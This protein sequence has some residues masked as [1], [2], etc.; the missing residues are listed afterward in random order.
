MLLVASLALVFS[1]GQAQSVNPKLMSG[2]RWRNV[3]PFRGGRVSAVSGAIGKPGTF[4]MGMP[5]G[6]VWKTTNAGA[7]WEPIM[8]SVTDVASI[9]SI[10]VAPSNPNVIYVGTGDMPTGGSINEGNGMYKSVDAGKTW[11]HLAGFADSKQIPSLVVHPKNENIVLA[12]ISGDLSNKHENRGIYRSTDGG[13]TWTKTLFVDN[14]TGGQKIAYAY[15]TPDTLIATTMGHVAAPGTR[16]G[17]GSSKGGHLFKSTDNGVTWNEIK[18][19]GL[20]GVSGRT[21]VAIANGTNGERMFLVQG[22]GLY[23]SDDG[24]K[25]WKKL[26]SNDPR[27]RTGQGGYNCGVYVN[28]KNPDIVYIVN[29]CSYISYDG[30]NTFTGFKGAPGGDDPQQMWIDPTDGDR[31]FFGTDQGATISLD[32]G[33][34]WSSWYNQPTAQVYHIS[35]DNQY[36]YWIYATQQD[37]GSIGTSSRGNYGEITPL[38]WSPHPGYEFGSICAD[39]LNPKVTYAGSESSGVVKVTYP[40]MQFEE[41]SPNL[42]GRAG[43]RKVLNQPLQF[44]TYNPHELL[45]GFNSVWATTDGGTTWHALSHDLTIPNG[46]AP[47]A[48]EKP[49][50]VA[51]G[52]GGNA[53]DDDD[54]DEDED[55]P[56]L[57]D[58]DS[59][60]KQVGGRAAAIECLSTSTLDNGI[61]WAGTSNGLIQLTQ[62]HGGK[63]HEVSIPGLPNARRA[64]ISSISASSHNPAVAYVAVDLHGMADYKPYVFRTRD[65]GNTWQPI[66]TGLP[67]DEANGSFARVIKEDPVRPGLLYLGTESSVYVSF[68]DG[69]HW[70]SL[71]QNLPTTSYRD[72]VVKGNDLVV[73]TYGRSFWILDDLSPLREISANMESSAHF[74]KPATAV[75]VRRNV[76]WDTPFP[77]EVPH[78]LNAPVGALLYYYLPSDAKRVSLTVFDKRGSEVRRYSSDPIEQYTDKQPIPDFWIAP[79]KPMPTGSGLQRINWDLRYNELPS[80]NHS[81]DIN[82]NPGETVAS[83]QGPLV[84]PGEY[85]LVLIVDGQEF[86]QKLEVAN[87]PRSPSSARDL[88]RQCELQRYFYATA[89]SCWDNWQSVDAVRKEIADRLVANPAEPI[90]KALKDMDERLTAIQGAR[91]GGRRFAAAADQPTGAT[92]S[93]VMGVCGNMLRNMDNGD[94]KPSEA[95]EMAYKDVPGDAQWLAKEWESVKRKEIPALN[96]QLGKAGIKPLHVPF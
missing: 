41:V 22:S 65:F 34:T 73:G 36:P 8:D 92:F 27:I 35:V 51:P 5:N 50:E 16:G 44:S 47:K 70:Q 19:G 72:M 1:S 96:D 71:R 54:Q 23:R 84:E 78:A 85:R 33:K 29:T 55:I 32:A 90:T 10:E 11:T 37:S 42:Y 94:G 76:N 81:Y 15:D 53:P 91:G 43:L 13:A 48:Q 18:G 14:E 82:A 77:P 6:G 4:Y 40:S 45:V 59:H 62:N 80:F 58:K 24:G 95:F 61:I 17:F 56:A 7:V 74:F 60:Y 52:K 39:P 31:L 9:G 64:D 87:D 21:S 93:S 12:A 26:A 83:P 69:D 3:G 66:V 57:Q 2:L 30:G 38:D 49:K 75:R 79:R 68:D 28:S 88:A 86:E 63:W 25:N 20:P 89:V 46:P 67:T